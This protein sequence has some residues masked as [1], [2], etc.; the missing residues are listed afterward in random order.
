L[1]LSAAV[2]GNA[3]HN[4]T[5]SISG[6]RSSNT[7]ISSNGLLTV[8]ADEP[9]GTI[10]VTATSTFDT[11]KKDTA[12]V[13]V[14]IP[15][16]ISSVVVT[17][18]N[19]T[20]VSG[21]TLQL[22][23]AV[24]GNASHNV[25]WSLSGNRSSN[26]KISSNGLLTVA[27]DEPAGTIQVTATSTFD[28]TKK[29]TAAVNVEVP[30]VINSVEVT[31]DDVDVFTG[32]SLQ[33]QATVTGN[34]DPSVTWSIQGQE[35]NNTRIDT[36]GLLNIGEDETA[37]ILYVKATSVFDT[38]VQDEVTVYV[39]KP[40]QFID[41]IDISY[42]TGD[43][44]FTGAY[45][46]KEIVDYDNDYN[47]IREHN[48]SLSGNVVKGNNLVQ[49]YACEEGVT[50]FANKLLVSNTEQYVNP[51]RQTWLSFRIYAEPYSED[52]EY[53]PYTFDARHLDD[54]DV[55]VNGALVSN[56]VI[57]NYDHRW[58]SV[59]VFIPIEMTCEHHWNNGQ[60]T[61]P[62]TAGKDGVF[63]YT[64]EWCHETRTEGIPALGYPVTYVLNDGTNNNE[65]PVITYAGND[66]IT[67]KN[68]ERE[69]FTF[70]G[71]YK[72][73]AF[74]H[75][76]TA[77][78]E[79]NDEFLTLYA[80][81]TA[82]TYKI[83]FSPNYDY[84]GDPDFTAMASMTNRA[85]GT[86]YKL[87]A[88]TYSQRGYQFAGWNTQ[89]D[90]SGDFYEN[91]ATVMNL[92]TENGSTVYLYAQWTP[93]TY[94]VIFSPNYDYAD[95]PDFEVMPSMVDVEYG[96][97]YNLSD[98]TY[99][100]D[101]YTFLGWNTKRD[102]TGTSYDNMEQINSLSATDGG[103]VYLYAQWKTHTYKIVFS[104]NYDYNPS[105]FKAMASMTSRKYDVSYTLSANTY[106][107][108]G[109]TFAGWNTQRDGSGDSFAN[110]ATVRNLTE[111]DG[112]SVYLYAQWKPNTYK[113]I[114]SP[115]YDYSD[116]P[117]FTAMP[118]MTNLEY[119]EEYE[120]SD[121]TYGKPGYIFLGWNTK[122]DGT[123]TSYD[124]METI[125][126]LV[127]TNG[128]SIYLYAQWHINTY[129]IVF[130]PNYDYNPSGFKAMASM[131]NRECGTTYTLSAN[132]YTR[133][134]YTFAGWNTQRDGSGDSYANKA[135]VKDMT[136]EDGGV[137]YLYAQWR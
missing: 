16:V 118:S 102:G 83:A 81:W 35:S 134:G 12:A 30:L 22:S 82:N 39:Q 74:T 31:P 27:A 84:S 85:C 52:M 21:N 100:R 130:S 68:P 122:R 46:Y 126:N 45:K 97:D 56:A 101:G 48:W 4:V 73:A 23:A 66:A 70:G 43:T 110:K 79:D 98:N 10:Q 33:F 96:R 6:N 63:T 28:T 3:S 38:S 67:L 131:T 47:G 124:N 11:T 75:K 49:I 76:I 114:F 37:E 65:N 95:D 15:L 116:D 77:I 123:G 13:N 103:L 121:I 19:Q 88:N 129:K 99:R 136:L 94:R 44:E 69:G 90:G 50:G 2:T 40:A 18:K 115:N 107:R 64:C 24:T 132:T 127:S 128:G 108:T 91:Q 106:T 51:C 93:N 113:V 29:D 109:Y 135:S 26:T 72:E 112:V 78:P 59:E 57:T 58:R 137:V 92:S 9:A 117:D 111:E 53:P 42:N 5:W 62:A 54:I 60:V 86:A 34:A 119:G 71:W 87:S 25:T 17:P 105:G 36:T 61:T 80:K 8:A 20:V 120:L 104:P 89:R 14:E 55:W 1:Q 125:S 7:K 41:T 32:E 133:S